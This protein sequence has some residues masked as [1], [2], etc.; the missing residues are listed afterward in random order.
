MPLPGVLFQDNFGGWYGGEH[1]YTPRLLDSSTDLAYGAMAG[2]WYQVGGSLTVQDNVILRSLSYVLR[3]W[4][5]DPSTNLVT[6]T[7]YPS[8]Y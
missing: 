2:A 1:L 7:T 4:H 5:T 8:Q 3:L 6:R